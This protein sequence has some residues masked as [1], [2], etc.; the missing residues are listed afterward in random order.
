MDINKGMSVI[1]HVNVTDMSNH[2]VSS[3]PRNNNSFKGDGSF[4]SGILSPGD[5]FWLTFDSAGVFLFYDALLPNSAGMIV[6]HYGELLSAWCLKD[7]DK[8]A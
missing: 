2:T 3:G 8:N 5:D 4:F 1:F 6:V 7:N